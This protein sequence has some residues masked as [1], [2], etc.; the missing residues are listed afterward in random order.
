MALNLE[1]K[2]KVDSHKKYISVLKRIGAEN[3]G[4]LKQKDIYYKVKKG[5]L[6]LR[7]ENETFTLIKYL[8]DEKGKRWSNYELM[9]LMAKNPEKYLN[10]IF[11]VEA[12]VVKERKYWLYKN[13]RVHL[14]TVKNLGKLLELETLFTGSRADATKQFNKIVKILNLDL[15]KQIHKSYK[16]LLVKK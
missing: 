10:E 16:N 13:T 15:G 3:K 9:T 2:I 8:R 11:D 4:I 5:L 12:V 6:K 7:V 14:D 1:L